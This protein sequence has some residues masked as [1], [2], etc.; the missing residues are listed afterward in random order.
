M[1]IS[2]LA[3]GRL[4]KI[5]WLSAVGNHISMLNVM[6][7]KSLNEA[8]NYLSASE[9]ENATLEG[10]NEISAF[11]ANK[12]PTSFQEWNEV[13]KEAKLFFL[14]EIKP[15]VI[16]LNGFN[17]TLLLQCFE[18]DVIHYLIEDFYSEKLKSPLFFH[19]LISIYESGHFPCGWFGNWPKGQLVMY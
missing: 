15:K 14:N 7:A 13:A 10:A 11:L 12:H 1:K 17:N 8:E 3:T 16:H 9:W 5:K 4:L 6:F 19:S 2:N 18:W